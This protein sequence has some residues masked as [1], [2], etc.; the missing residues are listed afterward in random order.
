MGRSRPATFTCPNCGEEVPA[1][2]A[3]CPACGS[4]EDTGWS[5]AAEYDGLD[6]P[7]PDD[8]DDDATSHPGKIWI[9][10][11]ALALL[12]AFTWLAVKGWW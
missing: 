7:D 10:A 4:D 5:D 1:G 3:A 2:A 6:L 9:A 11:V 12:V 8:N